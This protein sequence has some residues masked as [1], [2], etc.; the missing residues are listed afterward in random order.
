[1]TS[2]PVGVDET[3]RETDA[4]GVATATGGPDENALRS[5]IL[6]PETL[7]ERLDE[8]DGGGSIASLLVHSASPPSTASASET[9]DR[10][11]S[12]VG[13]FDDH[14]RQNVGFRKS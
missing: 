6:S 7:K 3:A 10:D 5:S 14:A 2:G 13:R 4:D 12:R 1:M 9:A 11:A 8:R